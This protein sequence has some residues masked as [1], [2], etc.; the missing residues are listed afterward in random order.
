M[1]VQYVALGLT[2]EQTKAW[3]QNLGHTD[4]LTTFTNYG[5]V[6]VARQG[7]LIRDRAPNTSDQPDNAALLAKLTAALARGR[8]G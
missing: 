8:R 4:V 6:P 2:P 5:T 3:S 1:L 7:K